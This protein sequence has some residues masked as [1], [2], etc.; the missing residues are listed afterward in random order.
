MD[1]SGNAEYIARTSIAD[2]TR[3]VALKNGLRI[4]VAGGRASSR[5]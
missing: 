2:G 3:P 1:E 5:R 4:F